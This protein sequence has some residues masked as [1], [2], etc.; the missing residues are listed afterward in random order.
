MNEL[1]SFSFHGVNLKETCWIGR[2]P[3]FTRRAI[4]E[5]LEY[6][7]PRPDVAIAKIVAKNPHIKTFAVVT[8]LVTTDGKEYDIEAYDPIGLQLIVMESKQPK[9]IVY[10][11]AVAHLVLAYING[12]LKPMRPPHQ[13]MVTAIEAFKEIETIPHGYKA[14][15]VKKHSTE[16]GITTSTFYRW[17][18]RLRETGHLKHMYE[19]GI[20][21]RI[22]RDYLPK[23]REV[24]QAI[25][26]G[27][28]IKEVARAFESSLT[29]AY[30]IK[31]KR[32]KY[33]C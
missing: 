27:M 3:Y 23:W 26:S 32:G 14:D 22:C 10:K 31:L 25:D 13:K 28:S 19:E 18:R 30:R 29:T 20:K 24:W 12:E 6:V 5:W 8:R 21:K 9:A 16:I 17:R 1:I 33:E 7:R 15:A 11:I 2:K 4:G